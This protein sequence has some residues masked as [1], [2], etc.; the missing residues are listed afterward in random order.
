MGEA[1][2]IMIEPFE[3]KAVK[4]DRI[5]GQV[6]FGDLP[7]TV[8]EALVAPGDPGQQYP[9]LALRIV[10]ANDRPIRADLLLAVGQCADHLFLFL[11]D[12]EAGSQALEMDIHA[13][14]FAPPR[15]STASRNGTA[16][17]TPPS[18]SMSIRPPR[19]IRPVIRT[20]SARIERMLTIAWLRALS[21]SDRTT[22]SLSGR[23]PMPLWM[24]KKYR[25]MFA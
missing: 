20:S 9:A 13:R 5:T 11:T 7:R 8:T 17:V 14:H 6:Q 19:S 21:K 1:Y 16:V 24:W 4:V 23:K 22:P 18:S 25:R 12:L 3:R 15:T 2:D 10:G